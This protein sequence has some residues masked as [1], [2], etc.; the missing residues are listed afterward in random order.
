[1]SPRSMTGILRNRLSDTRQSVTALSS[2]SV[3]TIDWQDDR[4]PSNHWCNIVLS[5]VKKIERF[6][7]YIQCFVSS[8]CIFRF[9]NW[10]KKSKKTMWIPLLLVFQS[11]LTRPSLGPYLYGSLMLLE[12]STTPSMSFLNVHLTFVV[13]A[14]FLTKLSSN[15]TIVS[16]SRCFGTYITFGILQ[17]VIWI[18]PLF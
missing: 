13:F 8:C 15:T 6:R 2:A 5:V 10:R 3:V 14:N 7:T 16:I 17:G 12:A 9:K 1:M 11:L 4:V 18:T